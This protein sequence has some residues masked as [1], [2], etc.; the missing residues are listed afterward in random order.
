M[1]EREREKREKEKKRKKERKRRGKS[2]LHQ[3]AK[4]EREREI[5]KVLQSSLMTK[6]TLGHDNSYV[7]RLSPCYLSQY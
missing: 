1:R 6:P 3:P 5:I 2:V 4:A 7:C